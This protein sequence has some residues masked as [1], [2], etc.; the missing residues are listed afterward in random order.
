MKSPV[1][2]CITAIAIAH[3]GGTA[4]SLAQQATFHP[5]GP[6]PNW[7]LI[8]AEAT[9]ISADGSTVVGFIYHHSSGN[10]EP[11]AWRESTGVVPLGHLPGTPRDP[12][13]WANGVSAD[14]QYVVGV[15]TSAASFPNGWWEAFRWSASTGMM[16]LGIAGGWD[17]PTSAAAVTTA[18]MAVGDGTRASTFEGEAFTWL[19]GGPLRRMNLLP[20]G[21]FSFATAV[22]PDGSMI[23][24]SASNDIGSEPC[25]WTPHG[26]IE[27]LGPVPGYEYGSVTAASSDGEFLVGDGQSVNVYPIEAFRWHQSTGYTMLGDLPGPL[28]AS[29]AAGV[30]ADGAIV[31]GTANDGH[32]EQR[33]FIWDEVHGMRDLQQVLEDDHGLNLAGWRFRRAVGISADGRTIAGW[34][35]N[36]DGWEAPWIVRFDPESCYADCDTTTGPGILD[37]FDFLCFG[38]RFASNDPYA[39]DCDTSTGPG[40]C[41]IFDFLCFGNAFSAGCP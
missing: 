30:S 33:A 31:V 19:P 32:Q 28:L 41:D 34:G 22:L 14:G 35:Y 21:T 17:Y 25:R 7:P 3:G 40:V 2:T 5:L 36:P 23:Y 38:N 37:I 18:G 4:S 6:P 39:C 9:A 27:G 11:F 13:G 29:F 16:S 26:A 12:F 24:G 1:A 10:A 8:R 20:G 15:S